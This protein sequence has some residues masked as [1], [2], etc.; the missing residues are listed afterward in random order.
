MIVAVLLAAAV[1][2]TPPS[3]SLKP[4]PPAVTERQAA[5]LMALEP[6]RT[7]NAQLAAYRQQQSRGTAPRAPKG[8]YAVIRRIGGCGLSTPMR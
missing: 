5:R 8:Q 2:V 1:S 6:C 4:T 7:L 3:F